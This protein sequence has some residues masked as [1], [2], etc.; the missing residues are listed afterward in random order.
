M[1]IL[2][3]VTISILTENLAYDPAHML[4][5][6]KLLVDYESYVKR[7]LLTFGCWSALYQLVPHIQTMQAILNTSLL[8]LSGAH[9][10]TS[11]RACTRTSSERDYLTDGSYIVTSFSHVD[12]AQ[13]VPARLGIGPIW[14]Q[15]LKEPGHQLLLLAVFDAIN[16]HDRAITNA[17][18]SHTPRL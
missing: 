4:M 5:R 9:S 2:L 10:T 1:H 3:K 16:A 15:A 11:H 13:Q 6:V 8:A 17:H 14:G 7:Y 12:Q 18:I